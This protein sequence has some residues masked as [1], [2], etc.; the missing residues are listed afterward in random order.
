MTLREKLKQQ[1]KLIQRIRDFF[2]ERGVIEVSTPLLART[3]IPDPNIDSFDLTHEKNTYYLQTSPEFY[4]KRLL[5]AGSGCIY[6]ISKAFRKE[7][8]GPYHHPEFTLLEWYRVGFDHLQLIDEVDQLLQKILGVAPLK[9]ITYQALFEKIL[10]IEP[11]TA[12]REQLALIANQKT[13]ASIDVTWT[14]DHI[15]DLLF[16]DCIEP[17]LQAPTAVYAFPVSKAALARI[18]PVGQ[19]QLRA[20]RFECYVKGVELAN[21]FFE[22][23]DP[24]VQRERFLADNVVRAKQQQVPVPIDEIFLSALPNLPDCSGVALGIDRLMLLVFNANKLSD[25]S[26]LLSN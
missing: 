22:L 5:A 1:A 8:S 26:L 7:S 10:D 21:G 23:N 20:A 19:D 25:L 15:L 14:K 24:I 4:M 3:T 11:H 6:Q 9:K 18:M 17:K 16:C 12:S 13:S 2:S